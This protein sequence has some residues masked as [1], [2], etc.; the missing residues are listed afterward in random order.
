MEDRMDDTP[1]TTNDETA[2]APGALHQFEV[3]AP[4]AGYVRVKV[5][6]ESAEHAI[7]KALS[8]DINLA[9]CVED[10]RVVRTLGLGYAT[11]TPIEDAEEKEI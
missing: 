11:V 4:F 2:L 9:E 3:R 8:A 10:F 7:A 5:E 6:A 1:I